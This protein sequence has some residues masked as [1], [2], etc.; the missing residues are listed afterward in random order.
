[1]THPQRLDI[2]LDLQKVLADIAEYGWHGVYVAEGVNHPPWS[3]SIGLF[4]TWQHPELIIIGRSRATTHAMLENLVMEIEAQYPPDLTDRV[5]H[6]LLGIRCRFLKVLP[7]YYNDYVGFARWYYRKR[8]FPLY[9]IVW[10]GEGGLYPWLQNAPKRFKQWQPVLF[11]AH[12]DRLGA[13]SH[14]GTD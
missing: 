3:Y 2:E 11:D 5:D 9:Q 6:L 14:G 8:H 13:S 12:S 4:E 1:M 10:A 7:R